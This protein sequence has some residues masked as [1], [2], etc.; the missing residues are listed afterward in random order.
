MRMDCICGDT[1][2]AG[3]FPFSIVNN[4]N[5]TTAL[6]DANH[7][8]DLGIVTDSGSDSGTLLPIYK[9]GATVG[10]VKVYAHT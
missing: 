7:I 8:N 10:Y 6:F 1:D 9:I 3:Y 5:V 2:A 4:A